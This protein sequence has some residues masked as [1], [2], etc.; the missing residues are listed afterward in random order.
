MQAEPWKAITLWARAGESNEA[1]REV[2]L[3]AAECI[4]KEIGRNERGDQGQ[5]FKMYW[6]ANVGG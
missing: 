2:G 6:Q 4:G 3:C 1:T 5:D